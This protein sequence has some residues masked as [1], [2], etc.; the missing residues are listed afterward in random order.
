M[1]GSLRK[2]LHSSPIGKKGRLSILIFLDA[3]LIIFSVLIVFFVLQKEVS[4]SFILILKWL[5]P[6]LIFIGLPFY[7]FSNQYQS[8]TRYVGAKSFYALAS[9]NG[10]LLIIIAIISELIGLPR[11]S[12]ST[13]LLIWITL[14]LLSA[15][16]RFSARDIL[17]N[18][19]NQPKY[20]VKKVVIFGSGSAGV[21]LAASLKVNKQ[22][23]VVCFVDDVP[24][25]W[26][27][28][29]WDIPIK[30]RGFLNEKS[31]FD[32]ILLA[33]PSLTKQEIRGIVED[34]KKIGI[35]ILQIPS[36]E[37]LTSGIQT[38]D[39]L[40]P[41]PIEELLGRDLITAK[42][43]NIKPHIE[44]KSICVT[45]GGGSIG[46]ELCRQILKLKPKKLIIFEN[47]E[48]SLYAIHQE[49]SEKVHEKVD[50]YP[51]LG[52]AQN[53]SLL[54]NVFKKNN[55]SIVFHAAAYKHV[56]IV[57]KNPISG[58]L[59]NVFST[60][61]VCDAALNSSIKQIILVSTD[62][63]VRPENIMGASKRL[64]EMIIQGF[65]EEERLKKI[66]N[67]NYDMK[68]FSMVRFGNVLASSG[69]VVPLFKKQIANGGPITLTH[70]DIVRYFMTI[71]EAVNLVLNS[72]TMA[73][74]GDVFLLDMG[75]P[76]KIYSLAEQMIK[77]SG[78]TI[79]SPNNPKGDIEIIETGLR[80]GEKLFEEL[81][82]NAKAQP[83]SHP[84]IFKGIE[85]YIPKNILLE[86]LK[87]LY[88]HLNND[89]IKKSLETLSELVPEW[90]RL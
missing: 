53:L 12:K 74:G 5:I 77:L 15:I 34:S 8:L 9:R 72:A 22:Y 57:E 6:S 42:L 1:L 41:V 59:N 75:E 85:D 67:P 82:L 43:D 71:T 50:I 21:Q 90:K 60:K 4:S 51:V 47:N 2:I 62:K 73:E 76:I 3:L 26:G 79:K 56:P 19:E 10:T 52:S 24:N 37:D 78:L 11:P 13:W 7:L 35:S 89:D 33:K 66:K 40:R 39:S 18:I 25:M 65:A 88:I 70:K 87:T 27:R 32:E 64:A 54:Q 45:G 17:I 80:P 29:I 31:K 28:T 49:L 48:P 55:V 81:L 86:K 23:K 38:I 58:I 84:L 30:S 61:V 44:G 36:I 16:F 46:T 63:A 14:T 68:L 69:S 83:S 20:N